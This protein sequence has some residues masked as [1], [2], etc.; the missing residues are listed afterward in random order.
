MKQYKFNSEELLTIGIN[1]RN[2]KDLISL[3]KAICE[4]LGLNYNNCINLHLEESKHYA[5][6]IVFD[7]K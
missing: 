7:I 2:Y 5:P 3:S 6:K 1:D 4:T